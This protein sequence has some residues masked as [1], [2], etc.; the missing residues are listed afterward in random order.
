MYHLI[1]S[2]GWQP[3]FIEH[4]LP[5]GTTKLVPHKP[6]FVVTTFCDKEYD[7][8]GDTYETLNREK[9]SKKIC[10]ECI[11]MFK[12]TKMPKR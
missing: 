7:V 1:K 2:K 9:H 10:K 6:R 5:D 11:A 8:N 4:H 12:R 3:G